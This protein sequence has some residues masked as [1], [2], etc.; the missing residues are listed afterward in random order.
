MSTQPTS[1]FCPQPC[2]LRLQIVTPLP[3]LESRGVHQMFLIK[4]KLWYIMQLAECFPS[5]FLSVVFFFI[6]F[7]FSMI[8]F[9]RNWSF[10]LVEFLTVWTLRSKTPTMSLNMLPCP[11]HFLSL[12][13]TETC[14]V[15]VLI[16][17]A[18][19]FH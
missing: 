5:P 13:S 15:S 11:L 4:L 2:S 12:L 7:L 16:F 3:T 6:S 19:L 17:S 18:K 1:K 14:S 10:C 9:Q 8:F